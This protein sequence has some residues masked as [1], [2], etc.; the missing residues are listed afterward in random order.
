VNKYAVIVAAGSGTRMGT[1]IPK[2]F[3]LLRGKSL[4][5]HTLSAFLDAF[6][7]LQIVVVLPEK[8][9]DLGKEI[10]LSTPNPSRIVMVTGGETRFQ[11]VKN[12]LTLI[13]SPA[14]VFVHDGTRCLVTKNLIHRCF[15]G[16]ME[17]GNAVPSIIAT[18]SIRIELEN[19]NQQVD[20]NNVHIIQTPQTFTADLLKTAFE[21]PFESSF[22]DEAAVVERL[23]EKIHLVEGEENNIKITRP[24]DLVIAEK[25]LEERS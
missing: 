16:A 6:N 10:V 14:I 3:L 23:G 15:Y 18:D 20:R 21:Q 17:N 24:I 19:G 22:T 9:A 4:L 7:D 13:K 25:I 2:Q 12:G 11:S 5:W 8:Y 1:T